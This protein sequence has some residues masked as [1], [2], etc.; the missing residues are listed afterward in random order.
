MDGEGRVVLLL[1]SLGGEFCNFTK[2][3]ATFPYCLGKESIINKLNKV[4]NA[5]PL[6]PHFLIASTHWR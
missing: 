4:V 2:S 6:S 1:F 3:N 5:F